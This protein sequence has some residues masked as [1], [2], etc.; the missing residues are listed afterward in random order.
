MLRPLLVLLCACAATSSLA[1]AAPPMNGMGL[2]PQPKVRPAG[3]PAGAMM[4]SP[5]IRG[6]GDHWGNPKDM[7]LGP[8]YGTYQGKPIFSEIMV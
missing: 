3:I 8:I 5:C 1:F 2:P 6:M 7:P 4:L